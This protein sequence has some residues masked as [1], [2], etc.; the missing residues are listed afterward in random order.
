M[1]SE[2]DCFR[3][4]IWRAFQFIWYCYVIDELPTVSYGFI[5]SLSTVRWHHFL[6]SEGVRF[7]PSREAPLNQTKYCNTRKVNRLQLVFNR[8]F[9]DCIPSSNYGSFSVNVIIHLQNYQRWFSCIPQN[10]GAQIRHWCKFNFTTAKKG[11][12]KWWAILCMSSS[13]A[14]T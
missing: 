1:R 12:A 14:L 2:S 11:H 9:S 8:Q 6:V 5:S 10:S 13:V 4:I 3:L 7:Q